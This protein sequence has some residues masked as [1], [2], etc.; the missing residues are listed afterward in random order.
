MTEGIF[1]PNWTDAQRA[2]YRI[3]N[4]VSDIW[5]QVRIE[6]MDNRLKDLGDCKPSRA[7]DAPVCLN[8]N[9][10]SSVQ[11]V[12]AEQ[13]ASPLMLLVS[14]TVRNLCREHKGKQDMVAATQKALVVST[15]SLLAELLLVRI[16]SK[17][18]ASR[19]LWEHALLY[20]CCTGLPRY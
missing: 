8:Y 13:K 18:K 12:T 6:A 3:G 19:L 5:D 2:R 7:L 15:L 16:Q 10:L 11:G 20:Y 4:P 17:D 9:S 14:R 1:G